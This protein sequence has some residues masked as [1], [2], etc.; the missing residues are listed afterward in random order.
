MNEERLGSFE[1]ILRPDYPCAFCL[2]PT[3]VIIIMVVVNMINPPRS[4]IIK[5]P[6]LVLTTLPVKFASRMQ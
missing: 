1:E 4:H 5:C 2:A 3:Y 6:P